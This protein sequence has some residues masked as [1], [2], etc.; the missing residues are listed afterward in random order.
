MHTIDYAYE[1]SGEF[2]PIPYALPLW[3]TLCEA[4]P[5]LNEESRI[6]VLPLRGMV[7]HQR[8]WLAKRTKLVLR[9]PIHRQTSAQQL[10]GITL[11]TDGWSLELGPISPRPLIGYPS[12][13]AFGVLGPADEC[14]FMEGVRESL[15]AMGIVGQL[16][17]G[18]AQAGMANDHCQSYSLVIHHLNP[19]HSLQLQMEGLGSHQHLGYGLF[20][21]YKAIPNLEG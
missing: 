3:N 14:A 8:L 13:H 10:S 18:Q 4:A 17:C 9:L 16:I 12:L 19:E 5:W 7:Q 15:T 6:G 2:L 21:P 11:T 20:V 1:I